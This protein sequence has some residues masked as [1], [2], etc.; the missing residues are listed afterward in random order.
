MTAQQYVLIGNT[1]KGYLT[2]LYQEGKVIFKIEENKMLWEMTQ[3]E[4]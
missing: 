2:N 4:G 3:K 1:V